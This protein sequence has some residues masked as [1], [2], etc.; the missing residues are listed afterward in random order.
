MMK[1]DCAFCG[2]PVDD[3]KLGTVIEVRGWARVRDAGGTNALRGKTPMGRA[4]HDVCLDI[5][6]RGGHQ[7]SLL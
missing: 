2:L 5:H 6:L 4:A 1:V 7:E 3:T